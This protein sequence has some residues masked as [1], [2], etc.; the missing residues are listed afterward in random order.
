MVDLIA[1]MRREIA[2]E[3]KRCEA[4]TELSPQIDTA[5]VD[6]FCDKLD[7]VIDSL[8][9]SQQF[10]RDYFIRQGGDKNA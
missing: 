3:D 6:G 5:V 2:A 10:Y 8:Q 7:F 4:Q 9:Q 1:L